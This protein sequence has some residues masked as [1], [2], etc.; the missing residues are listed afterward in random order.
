MIEL[1]IVLGLILL[2]GVFALSELA[3]VSARRS[4]LKGM[5]AAG[6]KGAQSALDLASDPGRFLSVVQ[7][8]ITLIGIINGAYAGEA[9][10][11]GATAQ[12][13]S[14]G[15]PPGVAGPLGY[16]LV[17]VVITYLSVIVG[18]LVAAGVRL[19]RPVDGKRDTGDG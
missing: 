3:V 16:G 4:R 19:A 15:V 5:A 8:G 12:L 10:G 13:I 7:I 18:E 17:I 9:F 1:V 14:L 2:N 11:A 6:R